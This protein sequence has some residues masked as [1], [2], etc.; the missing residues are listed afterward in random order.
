MRWQISSWRYFGRMNA[1][2]G[3][4]ADAH[5]SQ[6]RTTRRSIATR[7]IDRHN[8][9]PDAA[10]VT[11]SHVHVIVH[12]YALVSLYLMG[13]DQPPPPNRSMF[14]ASTRNASDA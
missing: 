9:M 8:L 14:I 4:T 5:E 7:R 11:D 13:A 10:M 6:Q 3:G 12:T 1:N 2:D